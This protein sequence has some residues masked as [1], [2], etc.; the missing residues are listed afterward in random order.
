MTPPTDLPTVAEVRAVL[1]DHANYDDCYSG[2]C[3]AKTMY[4][5]LD[6]DTQVIVTRDS[7]AA[8]LNRTKWWERL[9]GP[10][11]WTNGEMA[12]AILSAFREV[13]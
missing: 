7:L 4:P 12:D 1:E 2:H 3:P 11:A 6:P 10:A 5:R 9:A 8:A 13:K